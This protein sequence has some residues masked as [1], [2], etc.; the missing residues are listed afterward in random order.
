MDPIVFGPDL[1]LGIPVMD[2][3]HRIV[4]DLLEAMRLL[5]R[6]AFDDACRRLSTELAADL[7]EENQLMRDINYAPAV[8]HQAAHNSLLAEIDRAQCLLANGDETGSREIIRSLPDW[9]EA[10]INTMDLA[11]AIAV[12]RI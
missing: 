4:F 2:H 3:S 11:W 12:T 6:P 10:H 9:V 8:V 5:P 7:S 1:A